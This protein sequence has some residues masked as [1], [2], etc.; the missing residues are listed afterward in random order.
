[1]NLPMDYSR[2]FAL[3][4]RQNDVDKVLKQG[5][6]SLVVYKLEKLMQFLS[7][8]YLCRGHDCNFLEVVV[9]HDG[10]HT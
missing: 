4:S 5:I 7:D 10:K 2:C 1:M 6:R 8:A 9:R 3:R